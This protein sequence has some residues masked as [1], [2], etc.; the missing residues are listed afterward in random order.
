MNYL[1]RQESHNHF[2]Q[3]QIRKVVSIKSGFFSFS[4]T[5][6]ARL[7]RSKTQRGLLGEIIAYPGIDRNKQQQTHLETEFFLLRS[8]CF[9]VCQINKSVTSPEAAA[10]FNAQIL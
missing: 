8:V 4:T 9:T 10:T 1:F 3:S 5:W 7:S 2:S 6:P